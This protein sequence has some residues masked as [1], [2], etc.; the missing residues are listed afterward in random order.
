MQVC[1][2]HGHGH[3]LVAA[4]SSSRDDGTNIIPK[5]DRKT[6]V[7]NVGPTIVDRPTSLYIEYWGIGAHNGSCLARSEKWRRDSHSLYIMSLSTGIELDAAQ[8]SAIV[9]NVEHFLSVRPSLPYRTFFRPSSSIL[10]VQSEESAKRAVNFR[11]C[12]PLSFPKLT[13]SVC[14][15][16]GGREGRSRSDNHHATR[17]RS[18]PFQL[19]V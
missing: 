15:G 10:C 7:S 11:L 3:R 13:K 17:S 1:H 6:S 14:E 19:G 16:K 4:I 2:F 8:R 5:S 9:G 12:C 18:L